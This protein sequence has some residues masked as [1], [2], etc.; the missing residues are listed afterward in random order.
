MITD[1]RVVE[2]AQASKN[3]APRWQIEIKRDGSDQWET[4]PYVKLDRKPNKECEPPCSWDQCD[5]NCKWKEE[6]K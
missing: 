4:L 2:W 1:I 3:H 6:S 5:G